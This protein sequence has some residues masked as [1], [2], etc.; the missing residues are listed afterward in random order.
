MVC[1]VCSCCAT[2]PYR[3]VCTVSLAANTYCMMEGHNHAH[4]AQWAPGSNLAVRMNRAID[5]RPAPLFYANALIDTEN[6]F[7]KLLLKTH[8]DNVRKRTDKVYNKK[9]SWCWDSQPSVGIFGNFFN[10]RQQHSNMVRREP[11]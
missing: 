3:E 1:V 8:V 4:L 11:A 2:S 5:D 10:F 9:P 6:A 7:L